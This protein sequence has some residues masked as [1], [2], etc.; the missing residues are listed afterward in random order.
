M[1]A[2][3]PTYEVFSPLG[4]SAGGE[5]RTGPALETLEGAKVALL[6]DWYFKGDEIF[7]LIKA[8][9]SE[10]YPGMTF[11]G[12][13]FFGSTHGDREDEVIAELPELLRAEKVDAVISA[14]GA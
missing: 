2:A 14:V 12:P 5:M 3:E 4:R 6:W 9:L 8:D 10:R 7:E 13:D 1:T 11:I